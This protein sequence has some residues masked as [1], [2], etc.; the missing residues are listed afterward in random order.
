MN[1]SKNQVSPALDKQDITSIIPPI[2]TSNTQ[3]IRF[4]ILMVLTKLPSCS[5]IEFKRLGVHALAPRIWDLRHKFNCEID[6][7]AVD[8]FDDAGVFHKGIA[9]YVLKSSPV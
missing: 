8:E 1:N 6:T 2:K 4:Y 7:V 5:T 9:R 3:A